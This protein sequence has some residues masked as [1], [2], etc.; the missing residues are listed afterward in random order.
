MTTSTFI[1]YIRSCKLGWL[2]NRDQA[3]TWPGWN[4]SELTIG[5]S[6]SPC[7]TGGNGETKDVVFL[8]YSITPSYWSRTS[9]CLPGLSGWALERYCWLLKDFPLL[10]SGYWLAPDT[11]SM[12]WSV[13]CLSRFRYGSLRKV[14]LEEVPWFGC[15]FW[16]HAPASLSGCLLL[17]T[18]E[19]A[20][21]HS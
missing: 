19:L 13:S 18:E 4:F 14:S 10:S 11:W 5:L 7:G 3:E 17:C 6:Q 8:P 15:S 1:A 21:S 9:A 2:D 16:R 20:S 12:E